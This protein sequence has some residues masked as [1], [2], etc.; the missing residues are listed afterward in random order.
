MVQ[1]L[2]E[3][4]KKSSTATKGFYPMDYAVVS[5]RSY[6]VGQEAANELLNE[7]FESDKVHFIPAKAF[8]EFLD[9]QESSMTGMLMNAL[10]RGIQTESAKSE[11]DA[12]RA[13]MG[14]SF[15]A[16]YC[17]KEV[18]AMRVLELVREFN[19]MAFDYYQPGGVQSPLQPGPAD[20]VA[21]RK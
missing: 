12:E 5:F 4:F 7:G 3:F 20:P 2:N 6:S 13:R 15:V 21:I 19:P 1:D 14:A 10:S 11:S 8:L 17:P 18:D 9:E 16:V